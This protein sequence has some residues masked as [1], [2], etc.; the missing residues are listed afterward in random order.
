M[1]GLLLVDDRDGRVLAQFFDA[2]E[3]LR[4][5]EALE[6]EAPELADSL[7]LVTLEEHQGAVISTQMT[8]RIR[9]L[10]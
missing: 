4:T 8:T 6:L 2:A 10:T 9:S 7:C 1:H 3:A 5:L